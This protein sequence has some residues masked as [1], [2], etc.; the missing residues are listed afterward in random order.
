MRTILLT[1]FEAFG[2]D[3]RNPSADAVAA[4]AASYDGPDR[5]ITATLPVSYEGSALRLRSLI[6]DHDP[7]AVIAT[8]L[9][10]GSD[11]VAVER[12]GIN[13][14]DARIADNDGARPIDQPCEPDGPAARFA[15]A[16]VKH[17]VASLEEEGIPARASLSA[18]AY[19]CNHVLYTALG[20]VP[21]T[22][23]TGFV[24]LPWSTSTAP[25]G[26]PSLPDDVIARAVRRCVDLIFEPERPVPG[27][28]VW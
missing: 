25:A 24:H 10:G 16:P 26:A 27:G 1:G 8:G 13:L 21:A 15:T 19:V 9:A 12:V 28:A 22:V 7:D 6:A 17:V 4:V 20:A 2:G 14:M 3:S 11:R 18:G 5:L 23:P